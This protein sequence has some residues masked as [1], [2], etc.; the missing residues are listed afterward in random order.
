M[1]LNKSDKIRKLISCKLESLNDLTNDEKSFHIRLQLVNMIKI[2]FDFAYYLCLTP[3]R[4][5]KTEKS[6]G[7][8]YICHKWKPQQVISLSKI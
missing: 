6:N 5:V 7:I 1:K 4:L 8:L 2:Y 3:F